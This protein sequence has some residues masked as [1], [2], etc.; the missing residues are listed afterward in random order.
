MDNF[1][2]QVYFNNSVVNYIIAIG[3]F[4]IGIVLIKVFKKIVL[5]KL[6]AITSKT[7]TNIDDFLVRGLE[8]FAIPIFYYWVFLAAIRTLNIPE[9]IEIFIE[10]IGIIIVTF[11]VIRII[12][13][14]VRFG[15]N[16]YLSKQERGEEKQ[17]QIRGILTIFGILIWFIGFIFLLDNFGY[18]V[19]AVIAGL[20][21]GGIAIALAAQTVL[22][23][24]FS[25]F[26]IFFDRP[27][28]VG[29]FIIVGDKLGTVEYIGIKTTRLRSITGEQLVI[30][31]SDLTNSRVHNYKRMERRRIIFK[32]GVVYQTKAEDLRMIPQLVK[33]IIIAQGDT[34][35]DRGHFAGFGDFSLNFEFVYFVQSPEY[36]R[37]MDDQEAINLKIFEEFQK[38]GIEFAYPTQTIYLT[39]DNIPIK[40]EVN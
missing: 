13:A 40:S 16:A 30:S 37:Y 36:A 4:L 28:E 33:E 23:D 12:L 15:L 39:K 19:S 29:D 21:I 24:L 17:K 22:G 34:E 27:F 2:N 26:V 7:D 3:T 8:K 38:R 14:V 20:G 35:F 31:N 6:K 9:G 5:F 32:F 1:L 25:Y 11:F 10:R 18:N